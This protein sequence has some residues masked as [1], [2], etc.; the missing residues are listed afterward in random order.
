[1]DPEKLSEIFIATIA[2]KVGQKLA[3]W[4][5]RAAPAQ[6]RRVSGSVRSSW[7]RRWRMLAVMVD[8]VVIAGGGWWFWELSWEGGAVSGSVV[9][10]AVMLGWAVVVSW[11]D[12]WQGE[13]PK[14]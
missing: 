2:A 11:R 8:G 13:S 6:M 1:M 4:I 9:A 7:R 14:A 12:L 3:G 5:I 10:Q